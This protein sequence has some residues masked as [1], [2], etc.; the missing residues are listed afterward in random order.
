MDE[1]GGD[2]VLGL[3][4]DGIVSLDESEFHELTQRLDGGTWRQQ[5]GSG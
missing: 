3:F 4:Q 5:A 1:H 2:T